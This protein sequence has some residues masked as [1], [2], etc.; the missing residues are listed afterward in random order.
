MVE[1]LLAMGLPTAVFGAF[2]LLSVWLGAESRPWF[3]E[4]PVL[5]DRPNW[6]PVRRSGL[7]EEDDDEDEDE[8]PPDGTPA[9]APA[10][11]RAQPRPAAVAAR[12]ATSPSGV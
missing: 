6:W 4:R 10:P 11:P 3:D 2:A 5:D 1:V 12:A 9:P 7:P 8:E